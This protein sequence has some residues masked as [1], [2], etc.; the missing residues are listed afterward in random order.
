M[1]GIS[2]KYC[3]RIPG[4][5]SVSRWAAPAALAAAAG[6]CVAACGS[7][8]RSFSA[9]EFVEEINSHGA[10][11]ELGAPLDTNEPGAE[12]YALTL[13][14]EGE[15][16]KEAELGHEHGGG[17]LKV[18]EDAEAAEAE[19]QRCEEAATLLCYRA[20]NVAVIL[21]PEAEP[22]ALARVAEAFRAM[23]RD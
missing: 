21:Q 12:L 15:A 10:G 17:S 7:S 19:Y 5:G 11:V 23:Q 8:D 1:K 16:G 13:E 6:I 18:A 20:A 3:E 22:E 2:T 14:E 9:E 4:P